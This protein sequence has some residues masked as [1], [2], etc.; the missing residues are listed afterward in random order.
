MDHALDW[1]EPE[2]TRTGNMRSKI[3]LRT[4]GT[5]DDR[6]QWD[7]HIEWF[8]EYGERFHEVF[9]GRLQRL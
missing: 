2:E 5:L 8:F 7:E 3:Q 4:D 9:G 6:E 1:S